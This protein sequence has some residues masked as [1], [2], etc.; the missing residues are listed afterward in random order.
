MHKL[1]II[2][3]GGFGPEVLSVAQEMVDEDKLCFKGFLD[4]SINLGDSGFLYPILGRCDEYIPEEGDRFICAIG[5]PNAKLHVCNQL[6]QK[7]AIFINLIHSSAFVADDAELGEGLI[8]FP[9]IFI[10]TGTKLGNFVTLNV[11]TVIGHNAVLE[12]GCTLSP[13]SVVSGFVHLE[14]GVF[15]G[16]HATVLPGKTVGEFARVGA[17]SVVMRDTL[18]RHTVFGVPAKTIMEN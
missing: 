4:D 1:I 17:G 18:A 12:T 10:S 7:G 3:A 5:N 14:Q 8:A 16:S 9:N 15:M 6:K 2:G 13:Q 11:S